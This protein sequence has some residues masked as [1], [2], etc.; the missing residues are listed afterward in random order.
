MAEGGVAAALG[1]VEPKDNWKV[2]FRDTMKGGRY[3]NQWRMAQLHAMEAPDRVKELEEWGALFDRTADGRILQRN[4]GGHKY[5]RLAH[6][7][8][9][10]GLEMIRTLQQHGIHC[11]MQVYMECTVTRLLG[12]GDRVQ[13]A[14]SATGA[15]TGASSSSSA[16][17][18]VLATGGIGRAFRINS[19]SWE[20]TGRRAGARLPR[21]RRAHGHGVHA[22][23][24]DRDGLAAERARDAHHRGRARR[25][26]DAAEQG[27]QAHHVRRTSRSSTPTRRRATEDEADQWLRESTSGSA[28]KARAHA[29]PPAARHRGA[30]H[31]QRGEGRARLARTAASSSTSTRAASPRTSSGSS[32]RCTTSSRSWATSTSRRS[33]W[34]S[35]RPRTTRWAASASIRRRRSRASRGSS[36]PASARRGCTGPTGSAATRSR[37]LL[38][39]GRIAG[40]HA[41]KYAKA[42]AATRRIDEG[43][44]EEADARGARAVRSRR[45]AEPVSAPR[46]PQGQDADATSAS[47]A[48]RKTST[49]GS[50][51][52]SA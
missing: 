34:R 27:R 31:L 10:T 47:S 46:R 15:R 5:P 35:G 29:G 23:P 8:D 50:S 42:T 2:H 21:R 40:L 13:R 7:G 16:K 41:A 45:G 38:V 52:S 36:R 19:N 28:S 30:R 17:S 26:R 39:F 3:L 12:D 4:F 49:K 25:G 9:R 11:G 20:C 37:D 24:P 33:R 51:T 48:T 1:Y 18:V 22:V 44:I 32:R 43:E 6:V 14:P